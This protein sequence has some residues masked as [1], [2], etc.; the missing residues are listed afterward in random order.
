MQSYGS[1]VK[2]LV[3]VAWQ[4]FK[5]YNPGV[6]VYTAIMARLQNAIHPCGCWSKHQAR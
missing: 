1:V 3:A 4:V 6:F 5:A 2:A